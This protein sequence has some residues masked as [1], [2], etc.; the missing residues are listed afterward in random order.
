MKLRTFVILSSLGFMLASSLVLS[1]TFLGAFLRP[2]KSITIHTN[3][4][5]EALYELLMLIYFIP[6]SVYTIMYLVKNRKIEE[7]EKDGR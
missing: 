2:D 7:D 4:F 6:A 1:W 3:R 5:G